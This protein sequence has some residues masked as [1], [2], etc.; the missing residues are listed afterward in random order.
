MNW[1]YLA[2]SFIAG[3]LLGALFFGGLWWTVQRMASGSHP[4]LLAAAS[5][6][7]R[8]ALIM[9]GFYLLLRVGW[10]YLLGALA[11]FIAAR[12]F[13]AIRLKPGGET[14]KGGLSCDDQPR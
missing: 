2:L 6:V 11:G 3:S 1:F 13:L 10:P 7:V 4:Y 9:G 5:F 12:T 14:G 8:T